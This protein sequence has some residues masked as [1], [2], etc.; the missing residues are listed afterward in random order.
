MVAMRHQ[1]IIGWTSVPSTRLASW[2]PVNVM[3][4]NGMAVPTSAECLIVVSQ[5]PARVVSPGSGK[6]GVSVHDSTSRQPVPPH[7]LVWTESGFHRHGWSQLEASNMLWWHG[8]PVW[9]P[10]TGTFH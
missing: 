6:E 8:S 3:S 1:F 7:T 9:L 10:Y 5:S 4:G 2:T